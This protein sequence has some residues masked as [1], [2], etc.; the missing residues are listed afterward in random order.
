MKFSV[1]NVEAFRKWRAD[2]TD[3]TSEA[4]L[5]ASILGM[6]QTSQAMQAGTAFHRV[7]ELAQEGA[8][9]DAVEHDGFLFTF[10]GDFEVALPVVREVRASKTYMVD[11]QPIVISGQCDCI[12]GKRVEDHKTTARFDPDR[13]LEG[14]Q[15]R[16]YLE[17]FGADTFRWNVFEW[18][19]V[20]HEDLLAYQVRAMHRLEQ[21]RYPGM[22]DDCQRLVEDFARFVRERI[23]AAA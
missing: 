5:I 12:T 7:L 17:I 15:W 18:L 11:G 19:E 3:E 9:L 21:H 4:D 8:E 10:R 13:F 1:S 2:E 16:L 20:E 6:G 14:Y 23:P 22:A